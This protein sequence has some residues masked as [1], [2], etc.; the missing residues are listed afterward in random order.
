MDVEEILDKSIEEYQLIKRRNAYIYQIRTTERI[1]PNLHK[2]K[3]NFAGLYSKEEISKLQSEVSQGVHVRIFV[4]EA[5]KRDKYQK[6]RKFA[7]E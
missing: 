5:K 7:E 2:I 3:I 1:E 4:N 6:L